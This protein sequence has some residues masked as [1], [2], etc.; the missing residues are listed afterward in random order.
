MVAERVR[1]D[2]GRQFEEL[3]PD[4]GAAGSCGRDPDVV[5]ERGQV[6]GAGRLAPVCGDGDLQFIAE[7]GDEDEAGGVVLRGGLA[8]AGAAGA[9][10]RSVAVCGNAITLG[11]F[12]ELS[13]MVGQ[14]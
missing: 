9:A 8:A 1:D 5:Q 10:G 11:V 14:S 6:I 4:G 12:L 3:P 13:Q 7:R 2:G